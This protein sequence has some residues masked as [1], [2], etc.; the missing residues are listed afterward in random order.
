MMAVEGVGLFYLYIYSLFVNST[1]V[2]LFEISGEH[3]EGRAEMLWSESNQRHGGNSD[4]GVCKL[5]SS[6]LSQSKKKKKWNFE[7]CCNPPTCDWTLR[8]LKHTRAASTRTRTHTNATVEA[9]TQ[10]SG[11][12]GGVRTRREGWS[13]WDGNLTFHIYLNITPVSEENF[14][15]M[16]RH[17]RK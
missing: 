1:R 6:L 7:T 4:H 9:N 11:G 14:V 16:T 15:K 10:T 13:S 3:L 2:V 12:D 17:K 5:L 8:T